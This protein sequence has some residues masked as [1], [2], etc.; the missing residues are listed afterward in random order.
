MRK[1][2][3]LSAAFAFL[4]ISSSAFAGISKNS[5]IPSGD[6]LL[7]GGEQP[8]RVLIDGQNRGKTNIQLILKDNDKRKILAVVKPGKRFNQAVPKNQTL[9]IHNNSETE[10]ARVYWHISGYSKLANARIESK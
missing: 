8:R 2:I 10:T 6:A 7:L 4:A 5:K 1:I 9:V 3:S